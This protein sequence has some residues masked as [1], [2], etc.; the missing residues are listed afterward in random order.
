MESSPVFQN[1]NQA[2]LSEN[3]KETYPVI[4]SLHA[5][6]EFRWW[7]MSDTFLIFTKENR[8]RHSISPDKVLYFSIKMSIFLISPWKILLWVLIRTNEYYNMFSWRIKKNIFL[9]LYSLLSEA[10]KSS[11]GPPLWLC[12][13]GKN[14]SRHFICPQK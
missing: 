3:K 14:F 8:A 6:G 2:L 13:L 5:G 1:Q 4:L 7:Q 10:M 12:M 11:K 9:T